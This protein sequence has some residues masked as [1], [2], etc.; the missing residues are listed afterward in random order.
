MAQ[1][2]IRHY[3]HNTP[4]SLT[5]LSVVELHC[6]LCR[7]RKR[8]R[9]IKK[10]ISGSAK[11]IQTDFESVEYSFNAMGGRGFTIQILKLI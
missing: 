8:M 2:Y 7:T 3:W 6:G 5:E 10:K 11:L 4:D 1:G 9:G